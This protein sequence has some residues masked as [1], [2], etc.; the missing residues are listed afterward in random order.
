MTISL[1]VLT[2]CLMFIIPVFRLYGYFN[3]TIKSVS[4]GIILSFSYLWVLFLVSFYFQFGQSI[5]LFLISLFTPIIYYFFQNSN[6]EPRKINVLKII[7][8]F[9][10]LLPLYLH[11]GES[12]TLWDS[13]VSW[14]RWAVEFTK[15]EYNPYNA[16]Y[17]VLYPAIWS[18][19]YQIQNNSDLW[20]TA[21]VTLMVIPTFTIIILLGIIN[22]KKIIFPFV[23]IIFLIP[24]YIYA[25]YLSNGLM[26]IQVMLFGLL[27]LI[28]LKIAD[29]EYGKDYS[30]YLYSAILLAGLASIVK[31]S[32]I[33]FLIFVILYSTFIGYKRVKNVKLLFLIISL[34]MLYMTSFL[35][36]FYSHGDNIIGNINYLENLSSRTGNDLFSNFYTLWKKFASTAFPNGNLHLYIFLLGM[37]LN[38]LNFSIKRNF[39]GIMSIL[40]CIIGFIIWANYFSYDNRNSLWI[41]SF[42]VISAAIGYE[43]ILNSFVEK[44]YKLNLIKPF[45][46]LRISTKIIQVFLF[47]VIV[48][49]LFLFNDDKVIKIQYKQSNELGNIHSAKRLAALTN[50]KPECVKIYTDNAAIQFNP[51]VQSSRLIVFS[52]LTVQKIFTEMLNNQ[53]NEGSYF[54]YVSPLEKQSVNSKSFLN[55]LIEKRKLTWIGDSKNKSYLYYILPN[56]G[57]S[58]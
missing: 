1:F 2:F 47:I 52:S 58:K 33:I 17:P 32:G 21:K 41:R 42:L 38:F 26:D 14:N 15:Y 55:N 22:N 29:D 23:I 34:S 12:F 10:F 54:L 57:G 37:A 44:I 20:I 56:T 31:Q 3:N 25:G 46:N 7:I 48:T 43:S 36:L 24:Y 51:L 50:N 39:I 19:I 4:V 6:Q 40:F 27:S 45:S 53:C 11:I 9:L 30:F 18:I 5:L 16:A 13:I 35:I 49:I 28:L 8:F